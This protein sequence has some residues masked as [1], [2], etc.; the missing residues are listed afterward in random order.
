MRTLFLLLAL[1][2]SA[3]GSKDDKPSDGS[4][5]DKP[6]D[7]GARKTA[8]ESEIAQANTCATDS[9]CRAAGMSSHFGCHFLYN[10]SVDPAPIQAHI[11]TYGESACWDGSVTDC[12]AAPQEGQ[13]KCTANRCVD[14]RF[15]G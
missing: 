13:L 9:D 11:A 12:A 5:D 14:A 3:C 8:L 2:S 10:A 6:S 4:K 7:C 1:I 15:G